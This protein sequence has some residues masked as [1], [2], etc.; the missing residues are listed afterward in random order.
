[1]KYILFANNSSFKTKVQP[2]EE[3]IVVMFNYLFPLKNLDIKNH[4]NKIWILRI[5]QSIFHN[6]NGIA[7]AGYEMLESYQYLF[8][9][10]CFYD[11]PEYVSE[12]TQK[13]CKDQINRANIPKEKI[14][15]IDADVKELKRDILYPK[16]KSMSTG[17]IMYGYLKKTQPEKKI[18][19]AG[20][21][22]EVNKSY[23]HASWE[24][25]FFTK[26]YARGRCEIL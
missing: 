4:Q 25:V 9:Q 20:F 24:R 10:I 8:N 18:L 2:D 7:Y 22:S 26:E 19:L 1:M 3:D 11:S 6:I 12:P 5:N 15:Q 13:V 23:H 21:T 16:Y 14:I 17:L